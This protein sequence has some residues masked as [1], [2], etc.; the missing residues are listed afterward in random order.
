MSDLP[1]DEEGP[2][3][4]DRGAHD[5]LPLDE[6]ARTFTPEDWSDAEKAESYAKSKTLAERAARDLVAGQPA[7]RGLEL[8]TINPGFVLCASLS[9]RTDYTSGETMVKLVNGSAPAA[10]A[11]ALNVVH[12]DDVSEAHVAALTKGRNGGRYICWAGNVWLY[13]AAA[14]LR[15]DAEVR[16]LGGRV[17]LFRAPDWLVHVMAFV[18]DKTAAFLASKLNFETFYD[19]SA[20]AKELGIAFKPATEAVLDAARDALA[21]G[22]HR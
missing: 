19:T 21:K 10:P 2:V 1:Q 18:G 6:P 5:V 16:R 17:P 9:A 3:R 15:A 12:V 22:W 13:E 14:A 7:G 4:N 20:T 8:V 11:L